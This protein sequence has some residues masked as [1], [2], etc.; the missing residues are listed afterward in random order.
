MFKNFYYKNE[1]SNV[2]SSFQYGRSDRMKAHV[3]TECGT[4]V[5]R[6]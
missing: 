3:W 1:V 5:Y 4:I 6:G 2:S